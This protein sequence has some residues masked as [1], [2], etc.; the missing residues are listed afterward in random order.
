MNM[1]T[2]ELALKL[3]LHLK[4]LN[5]DCDGVRL[6]LRNADLNNANL[7]FADLNNADLR[8]ADLNNADLRFADL[9]NADLSNADLRF[10]YLSN[11]DL[12]NANLSN[13]DLRNAIT[14][15]TILGV[16]EEVKIL[17]NSKN[18]TFGI[19][20]EINDLDE[21]EAADVLQFAG[22]NAKKEDYN[23]KLR[24]HWKCT[25]D[26]TVD[27]CEVVSPPLTIDNIEE[28]RTVISALE[29]AG[30]TVNYK[31][32]LH[33]HWAAS[34]LTLLQF[35]RICKGYI[36]AQPL[37]NILLEPPRRM[38]RNSYL[39]DN[40]PDFCDI[41]RAESQ[42]DLSYIVC[43]NDRYRKLNLESLQ[44]HGTIEFRAYHGTLDAQEVI[45]WIYLTKSI[46]EHSISQSNIK[47]LDTLLAKL[48]ERSTLHTWLSP[49]YLGLDK[50]MQSRFMQRYED[51]KIMEAE[52]CSR[53]RW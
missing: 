37:V 11:A 16:K 31:C 28:V 40:P 23:H 6:N 3:T 52:Y 19:E 53:S 29:N 41:D 24:T 14:T 7:R 46:V 47:P 12:N 8:N 13:A 15:D 25:T 4:W 22:I 5:G 1:T 26:S 35:K 51:L 30:A 39:H 42:S 36:R 2:E 10:A 33:V 18:R 50:N 21:Y 49:Q 27:G 48:G 44:V 43:C 38:N 45:D 20:I 17:M 9:N 32:G 34:D